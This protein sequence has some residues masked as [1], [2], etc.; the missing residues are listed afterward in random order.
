MARYGNLVATCE[1]NGMSPGLV[2]SIVIPTYNRAAFLD[3]CLQSLLQQ[4]YPYDSYEIIV[5]DDGSTDRTEDIV[6]SLRSSVKAPALHYL[7]RN[8]CG[9][10]AARNA[11]IAAAKGR[12]ICFVDDDVEAPPLWL[13][14]LVAGARR[15]PGAGCV[16]GPIRLRLEGKAPRSCGRERLGETQLDL[17]DADGAANF[18]WSANMVVTREALDLAG[19]FNDKLPIYADEIEWEAR[20]KQRGGKIIYVPEAWL[21]HRRAADDLRLIRLLRVRFV[22]GRNRVSYLRLVGNHVSVLEELHL[23][24]RAVAHAM[25]RGCSG[26]LLRA[27]QHLGLA[28]GK[29]KRPSIESVDRVVK[30]SVP[31]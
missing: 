1:K 21:W 29:V 10:N 19:H 17:G 14:S 30:P 20:L 9:P 12:L 28:W 18:V 6:G 24:V 25:L 11:G 27:S 31:S 3:G 2:V 16:G 22:R 8:H 4:E 5:V 7:R 26:G 13:Q 23:A 15:H